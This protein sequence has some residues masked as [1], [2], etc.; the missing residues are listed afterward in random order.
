MFGNLRTLHDLFEIQLQCLY[1][2]ERKL[3]QLLPQLATNAKDSRLR[4]GFEKQLRETESHMARLHTIGQ[5]L[6]LDLECT[7]CEELANFLA[8]GTDA[9]LSNTT[10]EMPDSALLATAQRI[11]EYEIVGYSTAATYAENLGHSQATELLHQT[12]AE[13]QHAHGRLAETVSSYCQ[14]QVC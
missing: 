7:S 10:S 1:N 2:A 5:V 3:V 8:E 9:A 11:E 13:V 14:S 4:V 6:N 12:L